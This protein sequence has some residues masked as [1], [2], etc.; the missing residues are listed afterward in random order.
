MLRCPAVV[1][2]LSTVV[3]WPTPASACFCPAVGHQTLRAQYFRA[4]GVHRRTC[5]GTTVSIRRGARTRACRVGTLADA[6]L[7]PRERVL[8]T[9]PHGTHECMRHICHHGSRHGYSVT[10]P[11][12]HTRSNGTRYPAGPHM[13]VLEPFEACAKTVGTRQGRSACTRPSRSDP[14]TFVSHLTASHHHP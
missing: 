3:L 4:C 8:Q 10:G 14:I 9:G 12:C 1:L 13:V 11:L 6:W 2:A 7:P 5:Q